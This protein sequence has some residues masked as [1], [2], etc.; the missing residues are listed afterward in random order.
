MY[1]NSFKDIEEAI[2]SNGGRI[3]D[4]DEPRLTHVVLDKRDIS[5]RKELMHRT[6][7]SVLFFL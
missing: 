4:L 2:V 3:V 5:R 6:S 1:A 7:K